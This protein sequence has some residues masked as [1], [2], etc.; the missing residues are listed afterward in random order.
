MDSAAPSDR[1]RPSRAPGNG[2]KLML[3]IVILFAALAAYGEWEAL[4]RS[5]SITATIQ[6]S[7]NDS[8]APSSRAR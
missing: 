8:A 2:L 3:A 1:P 5:E 4:H 6:S 7:P